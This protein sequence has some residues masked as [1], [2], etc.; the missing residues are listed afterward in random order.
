LLLFA[1][2]RLLTTLD[3]DKTGRR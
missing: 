2:H 3:G 1:V